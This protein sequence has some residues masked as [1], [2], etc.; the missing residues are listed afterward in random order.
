MAFL[1]RYSS[2][3]R[4]AVEIELTQQVVVSRHR[5]LK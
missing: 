5:T 3:M 2:A 1:L 4:D